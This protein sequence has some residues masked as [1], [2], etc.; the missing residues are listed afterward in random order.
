[1]RSFQDFESGG[2]D[3]GGEGGKRGKEW[4]KTELCGVELGVSGVSGERRK[5]RREGGGSMRKLTRGLDRYQIQHLLTC[6]LVVAVAVVVVLLLL[7]R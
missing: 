7:R 1:M 4:V 2:W 3:E 5:D 6:S